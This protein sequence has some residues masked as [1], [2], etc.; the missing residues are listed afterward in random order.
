MLIGCIADD[1]TG[2]T[3]LA[4]MLVRNGVRT[5]QVIGVPS[6]AEEIGDADAVVVA[7]KSRTAPVESAVGESVAALRWLLDLGCER[8]Y[9][10]Y[11]STFDSTPE[12]NIGPVIDAL[13]AE[14]GTGFTVV[15]PAFPANERTVYNGHLFVGTR[16]LHESPMREHPLTPMDDADLVRL[17]QR[18]TKARV[19]L[20]PRTVVVKGADAI[21]AGFADQRAAGI[22]VSVVDAIDDG[23]LLALGEAC[24][25]LPLVTAAS[26]LAMGL[27]AT[28]PSRERA[29]SALPKI[30]GACAVVAGS[31]SRATAAQ[32]TAMRSA[33]PAFEVDPAAVLRGDDV[34]GA[35]IEWAAARLAD[36]PLLVHAAPAAAEFPA[37]SA[38][39]E[40]TLA[41]IAEGL[42]HHGVRRLVVA[43]GETSGAVVRA[44][45]VTALRIGPEVSPGVPWTL[46]LGT[47]EPLALALKSGNFGSADLFL[48]AFEALP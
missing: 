3:D 14:L 33:R 22:Q 16:L 29:D 13:M 24:E 32:V 45:G 31:A 36:G 7:L 39:I 47:P 11:C 18:Q 6:A 15:C 34:V 37:A 38:R 21:R 25:G 2:G 4:S 30:G 44:L 23:D 1:F 40:Q 10:K 35:A 12:G 48:R 20:I 19:G 17:L 42:V 8:F 46:A 26:G 27:A 9:F 5:V 43:G 28:F 41:A